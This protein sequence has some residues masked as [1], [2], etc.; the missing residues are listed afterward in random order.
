MPTQKS[1]PAAD[2]AIMWQ[3]DEMHLECPFAGSRILRDLLRQ[4]GIEIG[5]QHAAT[6]M[7]KKAIEA[8]YP[9]PPPPPR[10]P[11]LHCEERLIPVPRSSDSL[12]VSNASKW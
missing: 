3:I 1:L 6:L 9:P 5:R 7:K 10:T 8:T 4:E 11:R 2:L 12:G